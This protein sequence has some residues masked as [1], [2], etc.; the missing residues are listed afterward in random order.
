MHT[1]H[2]HPVRDE[3]IDPESENVHPFPLETIE[4]RMQYAPTQAHLYH[5]SIKYAYPCR[6]V[7]LTPYKHPARN[8]RID[9]KSENIHPFPLGT[10]GGR[11]KNAPT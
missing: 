8:R 5:P 3:W 11:M 4:G 10:I 1:P 6:G 9:L 7:M 2:K